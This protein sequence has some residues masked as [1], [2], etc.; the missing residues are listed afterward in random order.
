[1]IHV[2][3]PSCPIRRSSDLPI[4]EGLS[5]NLCRC[6]G[7]APIVRAAR[8]AYDH[9]PRDDAFARSEAATLER[10]A[11]LRDDESVEVGDGLRRFCAPASLDALPALYEA[12]PDRKSVE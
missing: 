12:H 3:T 6:T 7:Y 9:D 4:D 5:G 2:L 8:Q 10:L 11:A 1:M